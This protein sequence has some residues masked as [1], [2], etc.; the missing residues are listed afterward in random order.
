MATVPEIR[1]RLL[2]AFPEKQASLLA[3]V[4]M[5]ARADLPTRSDFH[6]LTAV[7]KDLALAQNRT[8]TRV[9]ELAEAQTRTENRVGELAE[10][11]RRTET[12][13]E[14]L[15]EA[16]RRT[17]TRVEELTEAQTRTE[18]TVKEL[19][20]AQSRTE[21]V[22]EELAR[23]QT[24]ML[25]RLDKLDGRSLEILISRHLPAY[26]G[27]VYRKC[28]VIELIDVIESVE[29]RLSDAER[30][31]LLRADIV[32]TARHEGQPVHLLVEV[33]CTAD[34]DDVT[35]VK[36]RADSLNR[37]GLATVG[38][39]ACEA[40]AEE[41]LAYARQEHVQILLDGLFLHAAA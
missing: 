9:E 37:A 32:A 7:V 17:E 41:T 13:V 20:V 24:R 25:I 10:A 11:Q 6:E 5:D 23:V 1:D 30:D 19:S 4:V 39:V 16:Q 35:R 26:V 2:E 27:R 18:G 36:R 21:R 12:R 15:A 33:S 38:I 34:R 31:D 3:N 29:E 40:I 14:E 8:E 22:V 28:R